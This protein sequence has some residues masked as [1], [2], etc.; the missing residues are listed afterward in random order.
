[1]R[2]V[3]GALKADVERLTAELQ[4]YDVLADAL[5]S[6]Y[7]TDQKR[8]R[9]YGS[10]A[11]RMT[12][13]NTIVGSYGLIEQTIDSVLTTLAESY[14]RLYATFGDIPE[15][16][17]V[18]HRELILQCLRDGDR[19]RTRKLINERDAIEAL[20]R[21][22]DGRAD[23]VPE[24]FT[25]STANY[26][27]PYVTG[28]FSRL[29]VNIDEGLSRN[30]PRDALELAGYANYESFIADLVQRRN[31]LAHSYGDDNI[32]APTVLR[33]YVDIVAAYLHSVVR[34]ANR[35]V[36]K[37]LTARLMPVG[38]VVQTWTGRLGIRMTAGS[39]AVGDRVLVQKEEWC[40][41]HFVQ[42][43]Q[44]ESQAHEKITVGDRSINVGAQVDCVPAG[45]ENAS[46]FVLTND[47]KDFWPASEKWVLDMSE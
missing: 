32:I 36:I 10:R 46:V 28:L 44:S 9:D 7:V 37:L 47:W 39:L 17:R 25:M 29:A 38:Q 27:T 41:S 23:L 3:I 45:A 12:Y 24:V 18:Q 6:R 21:T 2:G 4:L 43:L 33:A 5:E 26:R 40:T 19:A 31:D 14:G 42:S 15:T 22:L 11:R 20:G 34:V 30:E 16:V 1:M 35:H 8:L 13:A